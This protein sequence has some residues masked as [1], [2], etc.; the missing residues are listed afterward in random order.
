[1]YSSEIRINYIS[2]YISAYESKIKLLNSE[3][4][5][6]AAKLFELFAVEVGSLYFG[7]RLK[8][9]NI[10]KMN[11]PTVDLISED[12]SF[13]VQVSTAKDIPSK[14]KYTLDKIEN[15]DNSELKCIKRVKFFVLN[16]ES[17]SDVND[18]IEENQVGNTLFVKK[19]DLITTADIINKAIHD[20]D[21]Q[22]KLYDLLYKEEQ[23]I[24]NNLYKWKDAIKNSKVGLASIDYRI[25]N[26]YEI[27]RT[28][29]IQKIKTDNQK[30]IS[31][32]G[33]AGSGKSALCK[34]II[35]NESNII[36]ARAERF[37]EETDINNIWGFNIRETFAYLNDKPVV[38]F[39]DALE[40]IADCKTKLDL[41]YVLYDCAKEY[42]NV[43]IVTSCR[44]SDRNA[45]I[46][47]EG[48]YN[49]QVYELGE[50]TIEQQL[51]IANKYP[52]IA[53][54]AT[55]GAYKVFLSS[56]LYVN[57][58][59]SH[60]ADIKKIE[61]EN[62]FREYIWENIICS[63]KKKYKDIINDI[64]FS[65]AKSLSV[66][67][68]ADRYETKDI[69]KLISN[70]V[71]IRNSNTVRLKYDMFED[72]CFE[73]FFDCAFDECKGDY[74]SFFEKITTLSLCVY[75][76]Y[77][78]WIE[79][80][81]LAKSNREKFLYD[82]VFSNTIPNDWKMQTQIGL[83]KSRHS[84]SF[85]TEY[86]KDLIRNNLLNDFIYLTNL[87]GFEINSSSISEYIISLNADGSGRACLIHLI[88]SEKWHIGNE[89]SWSAISKLCSDY[90][91][92]KLFDKEIARDCLNIL[93]Y[94]IE[95]YF[96]ITSKTDTYD[97]NKRLKDLI[98]PVYT[99]AEYTSN[100]IKIFWDK[101][102][103][104]YKSG[105]NN[106]VSI[107]RDLIEYT[108]KFEHVALAKYMPKELC[109][110]AELFWTYDPKMREEEFWGMFQRDKEKMAYLYGLSQQ[111]EN[112]EYGTTNE[113]V[114][115]K[116]F[117]LVLLRTNFWL[118]VKWV[119]HF[120]NQAVEKLS[121]NLKADLPNYTIYFSDIAKSK[122]Y[123]G[124]ETMWLA[125]TQEYSMPLLLS[126]LIYSLKYEIFNVI[127]TL[128]DNDRDYVKFANDIKDILFTESNNIALLTII[129]DVGMGF[130][131]DLPGYALDL[132]SNIKLVLNDITRYSTLINNPVKDLLEKQIRM[133]VGIPFPMKKRYEKYIQQT[134]LINYFT[135][136]FLYGD[137]KIKEKC[138]AILDYLYSIIP[139]DDEH[140]TEYLQIQKMDLN[141]SKLYVVEDKYIAIEP[142]ISGATEE[143][144]KEQEDINGPDKVITDL[145]K[146]CNEKF[147]DGKLTLEYCFVAI[148]EIIDN[149]KKSAHGFTY[150]N[151][152][153]A[154]ISY[155]IS[156][157]EL[158]DMHRARYCDLWINGIY[159]IMMNTGS[160]VIDYKFS[161]ILFAQ[162]EKCA[163]KKIKNKIKKLMLDCILYCG[164]NGIIRNISRLIHEYLFQKK[165]LSRV[166]FNTIVKLSED[167]MIHQKF[168]A[169][170]AY[171]HKID[172]GENSFIPNMQPKLNGIDYRIRD[173]GDQPYEDKK[174]EIIKEYLYNEKSLDL[175]SFAMSEHDISIMS[176]ALNCLNTISDEVEQRI[177]KSYI[178]EVIDM[179]QATAHSHR[180]YDILN[181]YQT[182]EVQALLQRT[183]LL[184]DAQ[185][186]IVLDILFDK[187]DFS[188]F[189]YHAIEYYQE[190]F[191]VLLSFYFD[192]HNDKEQRIKCENI[193][194]KLEEKIG[195][196]QNDHV[197]KQLYKCLIF[198]LTRNGG[199]GD[200]SNC[201]SSYSYQDK[202]FLNK[203]FSKYGGYHLSDLIDVVFKLHIKD[204]LPEVL[205]SVQ[206]AFQT[207]ID[208]YGEDTFSRIV[209]EKSTLI[210]LIITRAFLDF[211]KKIKEDTKL[212]NSYEWILSKL[213]DMGYAEAA[214]ILDEFRIH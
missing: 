57:L 195:N 137:I 124:A 119:I 80:K 54:M 196:I 212:T 180:Y 52:I 44:T 91:K 115:Y 110:L 98:L 174:D 50:L 76:R 122:D 172:I 25:N 117:F 128:K 18:L 77:Q 55:I 72:I 39:I 159:R 37:L 21:F 188:K 66:G 99:M 45:F 97:L 146:E 191:G 176:Y 131:N 5:F 107:S 102:S 104:L 95:S 68:S 34:L 132:V 203:I 114:L 138:N 53:E 16:N 96:P 86:G 11:Y 82:L 187:M 15:S 100:W 150:E 24:K 93:S 49:I 33:H 88:A 156:H 75:R 78:I 8:N 170:Y 29:I 202:Q 46:K 90:S 73:R 178:L 192:S 27:D 42:P 153:I 211:N 3:G 74:N 30:N 84:K 186:D 148:D 121:N 26:E 116:S 162:I 163:N 208:N 160:F 194:Y 94:I 190:V 17:A 13:Y 64:V 144:T 19:D 92:R 56:P 20:L 142:T 200:W 43:R 87:Y 152:L 71:L 173:N 197:K 81:L 10:E 204:L 179:Y 69:N 126:D 154:F 151:N 65:R 135:K 7:Q 171:S 127:K 83:I 161:L 28:D 103:Q 210:L 125:T 140:A 123:M 177:V 214:V 62:K 89:T 63:N 120:I 23:S 183:L 101:L 58:I 206:N 118:G 41:L 40:F 133:S 149:M 35:E 6:D 9:L 1:M 139:N 157:D 59:V 145:I 22:C 36:Y 167:E 134:N 60:I 111:A 108:L 32:Q 129:S 85:F 205:I 201:P 48:N 31:I 158:D 79:N 143:L 105:E 147:Q 4:L 61:D 47:L 12:K 169:D 213:R 109:N 51:D 193:I 2:E 182:S 168:N 141:K 155:A 67:V 175:S 209:Q 198:S 130:E 165:S 106:N 185:S 14:I 113:A 112:Y 184:E 38:F 189:D 181:V 70:G 136:V 199:S 166:F 207:C 164:P